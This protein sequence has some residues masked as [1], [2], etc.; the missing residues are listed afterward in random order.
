MTTSDFDTDTFLRRPL[1]ARLATGG[2]TVRP[3]WFLWED[4]AF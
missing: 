3:V 2:P 1:T 4:G